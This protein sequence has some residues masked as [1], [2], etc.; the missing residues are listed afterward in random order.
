[1]TKEEFK[2]KFSELTKDYT[3]DQLLILLVL[4][5]Q[6]KNPRQNGELC[7]LLLRVI[8]ML[9]EPEDK[10][11]KYARLKAE[12]DAMA[13]DPDLKEYLKEIGEPGNEES[14]KKTSTE[15]TPG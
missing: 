3:E 10:F 13:S 12:F 6:F 7:S 15:K 5:R 4:A 14:C 1:M 9:E 11:E 2:E 8:A